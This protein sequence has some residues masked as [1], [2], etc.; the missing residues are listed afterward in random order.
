VERCLVQR[1]TESWLAAFA[2]RDIPASCVNS[3]EDLLD[4]EHLVATQFFHVDEHPVAGRLKAASLPVRYS[5][6]PL[7]RVSP[8]PLLGEH[9]HLAG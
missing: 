2:A 8:A 9:D 5:R 3:I 4:D 6:T 1:S 7:P